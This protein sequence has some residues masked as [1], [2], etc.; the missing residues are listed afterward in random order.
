[1]K[2][3]ICFRTFEESDIDSF[4][5]WMNDDELTKMTVGLS[6]KMS[7]E[8][9]TSW[10]RNKIPHNPYEVFWAICTNDDEQRLIGYVSLSKIHYINSCAQFG[11]ILIGD[12]KYQGGVAWIQIYQFVLEYVFE[13]LGL[14]RL[15]GRAI[16]EHPQTITMMES[17]FFDK[18][19]VERQSVF[20]NGRYYDVQT[21]ALLKG[22]YF[23]HKNAGEYE[24]PSIMKRIANLS[25]QGK[26]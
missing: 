26:K 21:H 19:G 4:Y 22:D 11:G 3:I 13:R 10:V 15:G 1:M 23:M 6:R 5:R 7:R 24:F 14:N 9:I 2:K 8:E 20:K 16:T 12:P 25:L 17:L 18:E